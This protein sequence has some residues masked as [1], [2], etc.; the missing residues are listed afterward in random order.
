MRAKEFIS[1]LAYK[2]NIGIMELMKFLQV[3]TPEQKELMKK[4][5]AE[6]KNKEA[7]MLL[8]TVTGVELRESNE[9]Q[10]TLNNL[11]QGDLPDRDE[12]LWDE[13]GTM[14][15][16][17][18]LTIHT[19]PK[20]KI[21]MMLLGQYRIEHLD[22]L[23]DMMDDDQ[24]EVLEHYMSDP[25]LS[26]KIIVISGHR[27]IDGNHRALAAAY[28][29]VP[30]NYVDLAELD[31][32]EEVDEAINPD[33][34]NKKFNHTQ[35]IGDYTY[36]A[37]T[38]IDHGLVWLRIRCYDGESLIGFV[39]F[40][41]NRPS[42]LTS[43]GTHVYP[44][45]RNQGIAS[46]MYAYARMLGN[47]IEPSDEQLPPGQAMWAAW[48]KSGDDKHLAGAVDE[49]ELDPHGWGS[50]PNSVDVDYFGLKVQ[51]RP[52][53]F[54]QLALPLTSGTTNS[55]IE[56]HMAAGGKVAYPVL[57][58]QIPPEWEDGDFK[59][60]AKVVS[61]E[62]RNRMTQWIRLHGDE[63]IQVNMLPRGGM[64]RR[65]I[66]DDMIKALSQGMF[67][68]RGNFVRGPLFDPRTTL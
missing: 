27:I 64:R 31:E 34:L 60:S 2:G 39:T 8:K 22:E 10:T 11:Y 62:G 67:S 21:E 24:K 66:T 44:E 19:M 33:I 13:I 50:T 12:Q 28:K 43:E 52:S 49:A 59:N 6:K 1:E 17:K 57:D 25:A 30:I 63:P 46:T 5:L 58:F 65:H 53:M 26:N 38:K 40:D 35:K 45:Y 15:L 48:K 7:L 20:Y 47:T 54:L 18:P 56:K 23:L 36:T 9:Q 32:P 16:D 29:G 55:E 51:M 41:A 3:A 68:E 61:H 4:L 42:S 37:T 14:D